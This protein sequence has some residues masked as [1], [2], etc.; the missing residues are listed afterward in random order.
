MI[1]R[2]VNRNTGTRI[3][4]IVDDDED[5]GAL[6]ATIL[7]EEANCQTIYVCNGYQALEVVQ[8]CQPDL[9]LLDYH[10]PDING[11]D[12]YDCLSQLEG[13]QN[14][15]VLLVSANPPLHELQKRRLPYLKKPFDLDD[16]LAK[17]Y[18]LT[19]IMI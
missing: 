1:G 17:V 14:V 19:C 13:L 2:H 10:L 8:R 16:L 6:L 4:L 12:L 7:E 5:I 11:L 3:V 15:P 9:L 18:A